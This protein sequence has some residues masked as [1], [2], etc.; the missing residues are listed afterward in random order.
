MVDE[1]KSRH[2]ANFDVGRASLFVP[3]RKDEPELLDQGIGSAT[4]VR[5]N[6]KEMWRLNQYFGGISSLTHHL[7]PMLQKCTEPVKIVDVGTGSGEMG[8]LFLNWGE[9]NRA[10]DPNLC[11]RQIGAQ[12]GCCAREYG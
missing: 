7:Y 2:Q 5:A 12:F 1:H 10:S 8:S 6:L 4:D 3:M 9:Q 11:T